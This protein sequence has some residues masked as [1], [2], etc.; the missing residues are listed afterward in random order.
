[1][2]GLGGLDIVVA[3]A[4]VVAPVAAE[5][6]TGE[7]WRTVVDTNLTGVWN[8]IAAALPALLD[9]AADRGACIVV[10]S[11]ANGG[12]KA[13]AHL[14]HYA[15][16]KFGVVGLVRSLATELGPRGVR[17][18]AVHPTAVSTDMIHNDATYRLFAP[19]RPHPGRADVAPVFARFH[20]LPVPW[21]E[22]ADVSNAVCWLASDEARYI[23]GVSLPID[24]GLSAR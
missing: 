8:T 22:P 14:A 13:P 10:T 5:E 17:V 3:N 19:D 6:L 12:M 21:I 16:S 2:A 20:S 24:A 23:T 1:M 11:S 18:N 9:R 4:G 7:R 15:A